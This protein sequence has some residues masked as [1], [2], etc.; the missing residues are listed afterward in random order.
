[1]DAMGYECIQ[2]ETLFIHI[3]FFNW[4]P[5]IGS[6]RQLLTRVAFQQ[7]LNVSERWTNRTHTEES[8][9]LAFSY[10]VVCNDNYHGPSCSAYCRPK[11]D[12]LGHW[13][14]DANGQRVCLDGWVGE[15]CFT[16]KHFLL[17]IPPKKTWEFFFLS[18]TWKRNIPFEALAVK[19]AWP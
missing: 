11:D 6:E 14:C 17:P 15:F 7:F 13:S 1:M 18:K 3:F 19:T 16:G 5:I 10:R 8:Q 2:I 4:F 12:H 9:E